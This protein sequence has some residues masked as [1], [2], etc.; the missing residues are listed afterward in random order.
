M[1][2]ERLIFYWKGFLSEGFCCKGFCRLVFPKKK[3]HLK[4]TEM[5]SLGKRD[6]VRFINLIN[7]L[8][9]FQSILF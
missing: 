4:N 5:A 8:F 6:R 9:L 7:Y 2:F 3:D 1:E